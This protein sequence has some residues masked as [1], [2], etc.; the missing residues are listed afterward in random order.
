MDRARDLAGGCVGTAARLERTGVA[1]EL[2]RP[3]AH[4]PILINERALGSVYLLALLQH[5]ASRAGVGIG[6][7]IVGELGP[8]EGPVAALRLVEDGDVRLDPALVHQPAEVLGRAVGAIG[9]K[10]RGPE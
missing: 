3:I 2:A 9:G 1:V 8:A 5:L 7:M 6:L 10:P 4:H